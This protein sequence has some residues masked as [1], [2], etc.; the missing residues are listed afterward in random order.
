MDSISRNVQ[1][2]GVKSTQ[3][4]KTPAKK[5]AQNNPWVY[6]DDFRRERPEDMGLIKRTW[7]KVKESEIG[8]AVI[9]GGVALTALAAVSC[10]PGAAGAGIAAIAGGSAAKGFLAGA[11]LG[12]ATVVGTA[13]WWGGALLKGIE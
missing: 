7:H 5:P 10:V 2:A 3:K 4:A 13:K 9:L 12:A 1:A 6:E 11:G 8:K